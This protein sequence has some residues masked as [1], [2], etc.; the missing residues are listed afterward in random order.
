MAE[1]HKSRVH[2]AVAR[3]IASMAGATLAAILDAILEARWVR[4]AA[5]EPAPFGSLVGA[6]LGLLHPVALGVGFAV[7]VASLVLHPADAPSASGL[8]Q[9]L[10]PTG[11][12]ARARVGAIAL[13]SPIGALVWT[14]ALARIGLGFLST[15]LATKLAAAAGVFS[16][17]LVGV[18]L[19]ALVLGGA[20]ALGRTLERVSLSPLAWLCAGLLVFAAVLGFAI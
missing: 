15:E 14:V 8:S 16:S 11:T 7:G 13:L 5:A 4:S 18:V 20:R 9:A 19:W 3:V 17:L 12:E 6:D 10:S 1:A 2:A